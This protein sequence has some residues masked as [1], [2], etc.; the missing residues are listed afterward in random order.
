MEPTQKKGMSKGCLVG[1]I[2]VSV[3]VVII[4]IG[5]ITC[6]YYKEDLVKQGGLMAV[7]SAK[8]LVA[9]NP[10]EG[11][12]TTQFNAVCDGFSEKV[13]AD[14]LDLE[15]YGLFLQSMQEIIGDQNISSEEAAQL[16]ESMIA[17]YPELEELYQPEEEID[18]TAVEV[19][20]L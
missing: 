2:I 19:D 13:K 17:Y 14:S 18:T 8:G 5:A 6:W 12:D 1:L 16:M 20:S 7:T 9:E 3:I 4:I 11:L 10:P 15:R